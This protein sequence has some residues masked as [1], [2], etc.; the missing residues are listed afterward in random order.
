MGY[1]IE[2]IT[3]LSNY[4][5]K[6]CVVY[7]GRSSRTKLKREL[8]KQIITKFPKWRYVMDLTELPFEFFHKEK[9]Y[10]FCIIDHFSKY[11][12]AYII[13]NQKRS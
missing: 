5:I 2:G 13:D 12:M 8:V 1:Y 10:L 11:G 3:Y 6:F 4:I 7:L 9:L